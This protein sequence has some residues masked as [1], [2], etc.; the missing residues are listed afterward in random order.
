L[1]SGLLA[2]NALLL[3]DNVLFKGMVL[4]STPAGK[5]KLLKGKK[6]N[7]WQ[8]RHQVRKQSMLKF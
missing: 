1:G 2:P 5:A 8:R 4:S 3:C 7:Y 6:L